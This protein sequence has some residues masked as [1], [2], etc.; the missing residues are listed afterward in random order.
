MSKAALSQVCWVM[1][2][3]WAPFGVLENALAPRTVDTPMIR[4][5]Q[6]N[7]KGYRVSPVGRVAQPHDVVDGMMLLLSDA[8]RTVTSI[9]IPVDSGIQAEFILAGHG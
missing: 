1:S 7:P 5:V 4:A 3:E 6:D 2:G 9:T 8:A